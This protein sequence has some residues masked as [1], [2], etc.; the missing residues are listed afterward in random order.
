MF[1]QS[2]VGCCKLPQ[3][4]NTPMKLPIWEQKEVAEGVVAVAE[5]EETDTS[6]AKLTSP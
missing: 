5:A 6:A 4:I 1:D 3:W 2:E